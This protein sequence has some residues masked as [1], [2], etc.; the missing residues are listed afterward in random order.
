MTKKTDKITLKYE[1]SAVNDGSIDVRQLAPSLMEFSKLLDVI[2]KEVNK[3]EP[4]RIDV[5]ATKK[6]SFEIDLTVGLMNTDSLKAIQDLFKSY[7]SVKEVLLELLKLKKFLK[8]SHAKEIKEDPNAKD[9]QIIINGDNNQ[10][11]ISN[12]TIVIA[13]NY[14]AAEALEKFTH[15]SVN[16]EGVDQVNIIDADK[17]KEKI[18]I[19][20]EELSF[21]KKPEVKEAEDKIIAERQ[22]DIS[23]S[24]YSPVFNEDNKWKFKDARGTILSVDIEDADFK[25]RY[26]EG[27]I[28]FNINDI[29]MC[30]VTYTEFKNGKGE[31]KATDYKIVKVLEYIQAPKQRELPL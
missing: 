22:M 25:K 30:N 14:Y 2:N 19:S 16:E 7:K 29:L 20:K 21:Y 10:L 17:P 6:G 9:S 31:L 3:N 27:E 26:M 4:L 24:I 28:S 11:S 5:V 12:S 13:Q 1:G 15:N 18:E 23:L 8:G